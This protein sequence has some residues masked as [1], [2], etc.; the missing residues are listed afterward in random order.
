L[1]VGNHRR[2]NRQVT[3]AARCNSQGYSEQSQHT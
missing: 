3:T 1:S 2:G